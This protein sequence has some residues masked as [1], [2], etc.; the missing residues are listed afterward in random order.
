MLAELTEPETARTRMP[1]AT[2]E[3]RRPIGVLPVEIRARVRLIDDGDARRVAPIG[4]LEQ[5][6]GERPNAERREELRRDLVGVRELIGGGRA[7]ADDGKGL[8]SDGNSPWFSGAADVAPAE[9]RRAAR[10]CGA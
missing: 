8:E 2:S 5:P 7:A 6:A 9:R 1:P 3:M 4:R 10:R